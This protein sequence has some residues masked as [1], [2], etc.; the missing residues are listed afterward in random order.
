MTYKLVSSEIITN[1]L[2]NSEVVFLLDNIAEEPTLQQIKFV[3][4]LRLMDPFDP[5]KLT[6]VEI[7][8][9]L[10]YII[11]LYSFNVRVNKDILLSDALRIGYFEVA[12]YLVHLGCIPL[13]AIMERSSDTTIGLKNYNK[14]SYDFIIYCINLNLDVSWLYQLPLH[15]NRN[16]N[17]YIISGDDVTVVY[18]IIKYLAGQGHYPCRDII[19]ELV[20]QRVYDD[21]IEYLIDLDSDK[22]DGE[23]ILI[24]AISAGTFTLCKK[25]FS[26]GFGINID[27]IKNRS[28]D[29]EMEG[30]ID[31]LKDAGFSSDEIL[32]LIKYLF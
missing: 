12:K 8:N 26:K 1:L 16:M 7:I 28:A 25:L 19:Y 4:L 18:Q 9:L 20:C 22:I 2:E 21:I 27:K 30:C 15:D 5:L 31:L 6:E 11:G 10:D 29:K 14:I 3:I 24:D 13:V 32:E 23:Q 17:S